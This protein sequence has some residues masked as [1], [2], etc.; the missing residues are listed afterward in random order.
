VRLT[1]GR[2]AAR[3]LYDKVVYGDKVYY[4]HRRT[5]RVKW[6]KPLLMADPRVQPSVPV[7]QPEEDRAQAL[8]CDLCNVFVA[9][10]Y[11][12]TC[13]EFYCA[14]DFEKSH[15]SG[16]RAFATHRHF[17][18]DVCVQ[19]NYQA[20]SRWCTRCKDNYCESHGSGCR[21]HSE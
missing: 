3:E 21:V 4:V 19:C 2:L 7:F 18:V 5:G 8:P 12:V 10:R 14:S 6:R 13:A 11:C 9:R 15:P 16:R 17:H 1:V 20:A